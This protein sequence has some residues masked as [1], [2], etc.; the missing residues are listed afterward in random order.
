MSVTLVVHGILFFP[1]ENSCIS[2]YNLISCKETLCFSCNWCRSDRIF[3]Y[4]NC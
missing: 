4:N 2:R 3:A 1:V